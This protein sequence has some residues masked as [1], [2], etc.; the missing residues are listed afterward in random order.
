MSL[1]LYTYQLQPRVDGDFVADTYEANLYQ[2]RFNFSGPG[3][4]SHEQHEA[5][6]QARTGVNTTEDVSTYLRIFFLAITDGVIEK[7]L[8]LYPEEKYSS[9]GLRFSDMKQSFDLTVHNLV[10]TQ[11][12]DNNIWNAM[13]AL[14]PATHG[15]D[16]SYYWYSTYSLV[17]QSTS[18]M[19]GGMASGTSNLSK[20]LHLWHA[21]EHDWHDRKYGRFFIS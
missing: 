10:L 11:A 7:L 4:I 3:V 13:V 12:L 1:N 9:P 17:P 6:S 19:G 14:S 20:Q 2:K 8:E 15:T 5:N 21:R 16:Q 18:G